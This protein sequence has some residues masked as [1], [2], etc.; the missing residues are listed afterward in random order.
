MFDDQFDSTPLGH[1]LGDTCRVIDHI[2]TAIECPSSAPT[3]VRQPFSRA[4]VD[5]LTDL[6]RHMSAT[7]MRRQ[8]HHLTLWWSGV[9][10]TVAHRTR[11]GR[12][13]FF[14]DRL[15]LRRLTVG[16]DAYTDLV[17]LACGWEL[18]PAILALPEIR[19]IRGIVTDI[20]VFL[21]DLY[22]VERERVDGTDDNVVLA[23]EAEG[24][25]P[26]AARDRAVERIWRLSDE[27]TAVTTLLPALADATCL[28]EPDRQGMRNWADA[29]AH[30]LRKA[31]HC[32]AIIPR[33]TDTSSSLAH[34]HHLDRLVGHHVHVR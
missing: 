27:F 28:P 21:D 3:A 25:S 14:A 31:S 10:Q 9:V 26:S 34:D 16:M 12:P 22:S 7:W 20:T 4:L 17:E 1:R 11:R 29:C 30:Y 8:R 23:W 2:T 13:L 15:A 19:R 33:Y 6:G 24:L 18:P 32:Q 5:L